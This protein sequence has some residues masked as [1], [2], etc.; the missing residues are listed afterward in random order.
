M[1]IGNSSTIPADEQEK[2]SKHL[3]RYIFGS[4]II[5]EG[6]DDNAIY[7]LREGSVA[8]EKMIGDKSTQ[9]AT[10]EAVNFFGEM[11]MI[12]KTK[13]TA[14][15]RVTSPQAIVYRFQ[16]FDLQAIFANPDWS[17]LLITRLCKDLIDTSNRA[18]SAEHENNLLAEKNSRLTDQSI[19]LFSALLV[20]Q[21]KIANDMI[22][23]TKDWKLVH[24]MQ[25][26]AENFLKKNLPEIYA[27]INL[28]D[29]QVLNKLRDTDVFPDILKNI[30]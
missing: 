22:V 2:F 7:L 19:Q 26:L 12:A 1:L 24:G 16:T 14:T 15:I 13:R 23:N 5:R 8:V 29:R 4:V 28:D 21:G 30:K 3:Y 20:L 10:I 27:G 25:E 6:Q 18:V 11:A 9:I 17:E